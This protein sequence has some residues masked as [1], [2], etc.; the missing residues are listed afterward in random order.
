MSAEYN[1][2][3][4]GYKRF[5]IYG[6]TSRLAAAPLP[7]VLAKVMSRPLSKRGVCEAEQSV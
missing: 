3:S 7:V 1:R 4:S 5:K 6:E 2:G